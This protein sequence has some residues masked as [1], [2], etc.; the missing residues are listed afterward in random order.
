VICS[1]GLDQKKKWK[2]QENNFHISWSILKVYFTT[3]RNR[4]EHHCD[5]VLVSNFFSTV[6]PFLPK[7]KCFLSKGEEAFLAC[8][9]S[10]SRLRFPPNYATFRHLFWRLPFCLHRKKALSLLF[11]LVSTGS[12]SARVSLSWDLLL[13]EQIAKLAYMHSDAGW[14]HLRWQWQRCVYPWVFP[15]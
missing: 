12:G 7:E 15:L 3:T 14:Q 10:V 4:E 5:L 2:T 6:H 1:A 9:F 8:L 11:V 13:V